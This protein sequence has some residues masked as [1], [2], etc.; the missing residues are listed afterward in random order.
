[1]WIMLKNQ[2]P[3]SIAPP[4]MSIHWAGADAANFNELQKQQ[5]G[6]DNETL[7]DMGDKILPV[8]CYSVIHGYEPKE[9]G[10]VWILFDAEP[11][12]VWPHEYSVV[13]DTN[14]MLY[15]YGT[16]G[17]YTM[18]HFPMYGRLPLYAHPISLQI[19]PLF[20]EYPLFDSE[21]YD[22]ARI[23]GQDELQAFYTSIQGVQNDLWFAIN[24]LYASYY[25]LTNNQLIP[26]FR[27]DTVK[28]EV[29]SRWRI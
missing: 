10:S 22:A 2:L 3:I 26:I 23:D 21:L 14:L 19:N 15:L 11:I 9:E 27:N 5:A 25:G 18:S 24:S 28:N 8:P 13:S 1:M 12:K 4:P 20:N 29:L 7:W 16:E 6:L 17:D